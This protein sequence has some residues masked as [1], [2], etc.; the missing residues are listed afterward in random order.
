MKKHGMKLNLKKCNFTK[1]S[2][3]YMGYVITY[4]TNGNPIVTIEKTK[5]EAI[6]KI[7]APNTTKRVKS[8]C[9]MVM[10]LAKFLPHL[11]TLLKPI[12]ELTKKSPKGTKFHWS[13]EC[14]KNFV[15]IKALI[16]K[17]PVQYPPTR[18]RKFVVYV[19][20]SRTATGASLY[21]I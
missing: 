5:N 18:D 8:F 12:F 9:G 2:Y 21:Q 14:E 1:E 15:E 19:D 17:A 10:Y 11:A 4:D 20:T 7:P 16:Q 6:Q 13:D 3:V